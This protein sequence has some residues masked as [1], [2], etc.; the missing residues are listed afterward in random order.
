[1][2][3]FLKNLNK[4]IEQHKDTHQNEW[5]HLSPLQIACGSLAFIA[6]NLS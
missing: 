5:L 2:N 4:K 1:M 3:I 6:S